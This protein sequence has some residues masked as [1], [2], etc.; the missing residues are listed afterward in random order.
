M[1]YENVDDDGININEIA[2]SLHSVSDLSR[3]LSFKR[4]MNPR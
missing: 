3:T 2:H 4:Q 1:K